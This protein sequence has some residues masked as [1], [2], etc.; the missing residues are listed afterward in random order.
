MEMEMGLK[1]TRPADEFSSREFQFAKDRGGPLYQS[2]ETD[3][4]FILTVHLKGQFL[5]HLTH[6]NFFHFHV[7]LYL[8]LIWKNSVYRLYE[9]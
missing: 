4:M 7:H 3:T 1:L 2:I 9:R 5:L 8:L 6:C